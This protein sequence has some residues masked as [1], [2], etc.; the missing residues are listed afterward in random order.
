MQEI[1]KMCQQVVFLSQG[2][3]VIQG[4]PEH[5]IS[6]SKSSSLEAFFI[7]LAREQSKLSTA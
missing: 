7:R 6:N 4:T 1:Q 5:I 2:K 3:I